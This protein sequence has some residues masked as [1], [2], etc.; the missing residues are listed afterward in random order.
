M[1]FVDLRREYHRFR[2][3]IDKRLAGVF[4][5]GIFILGPEVAGL[6]KEFASYCG[7]KNAV[8]VNSG[9][10]AIFLSLKALGV[11]PGDEVITVLHTA[12]PTASAIAMTGARPVYADVLASDMTIDAADAAKKITSRTKAIVPVHLYGCP[13]DMD[14]VMKLARRKGLYVVEDCCQAHGAKFKTRRVGAIGHAGC[15]S[16]Y[17]TKNLGSFGDGGMAVTGSKKIA[18]KIK[19]L[20]QYGAVKGDFPYAGVNSRLS[21]MQAAVLR[22]KLRHLES[23]NKK[24]RAIAEFYGRALSGLPVTL[25]GCGAGRKHVYHLYVIRAK[26]RD[27][28]KRFLASRG[29]ETMIHYSYRVNASRA[30]GTLRGR[31]PVTEKM[32]REILSLP[33]YAEMTMK[34]ARRT[35]EAVREFYG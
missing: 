5:R 1:K 35:A 32:K 17:P 9:T 34:E 15:F 25:P 29:I 16:F 23:Q 24:R 27:G 2:P 8:G 19:A 11:G 31:L 4:K 30:Y 20:R 21:E 7:A 26:G 6:E 28:L 3:A 12:V 22:I 13:C 10:D 14:A 18:G 33:L